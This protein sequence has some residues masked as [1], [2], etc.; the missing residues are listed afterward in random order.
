MSE[1]FRAGDDY[2]IIYHGKWHRFP[3]IDEAWEFYEENKMERGKM[4]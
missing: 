4:A 3:T 2:V 1:P